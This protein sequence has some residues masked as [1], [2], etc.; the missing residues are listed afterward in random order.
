MLPDNAF[1]VKDREIPLRVTVI[2]PPAGV[3]FALQRDRAELH[4]VIRSSG[5]AISFDFSVRARP[6]ST[7]NTLNLLGPF[8]QGTPASRFV[9]V[10]SG[11]YAGDKGS[12]WSR[13]A[14]VPLSGI[15]PRLLEQLSPGA[16]LEARI[17]GTARDGGPACASVPLLGKG[18]SLVRG[19]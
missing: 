10:N 9:Y 17:A 12:C 2:D 19:A 1:A 13:R 8:T 3:V 15:T 16:I 6:A 18:W 5:A 4:Q 14:K 7:S 11:T